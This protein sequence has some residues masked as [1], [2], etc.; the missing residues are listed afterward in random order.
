M[1]MDSNVLTFDSQAAVFASIMKNWRTSHGFT[2][3]Q[4]AKFE[5]TRIEN[6]QK[7][8]F[9][10]ATMVTFLKY[11][12]FIRCKDRPFIERLLSVWC[13]HCGYE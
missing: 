9:G 4:I 13:R 3:Y 5:N 12:D 7:V 10:S 2:L 1:N 8:E 6:I 11:V